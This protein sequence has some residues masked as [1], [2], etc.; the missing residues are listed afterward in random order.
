MATATEGSFWVF[1][2]ILVLAYLVL[3]VALGYGAAVPDFIAIAVL[4]GARRLTPPQA[5]ALALGLGLIAD[6]LALEAFGASA[7]ALVVVAFLGARSRDLFEG[8]SLLFIAFY[9]FVGKWLADALY[10][11]IAP[12][13]RI[14]GWAA[15]LLTQVPL[16]ALYTAV[17]G[18]VALALYRSVVGERRGR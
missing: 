7:V 8:A 9:L 11:L 18:A 10:L 12:G 3:H 17:A 2:A 15:Q 4:L 13:A 14:D 5:A 1:E 6:A 16:R